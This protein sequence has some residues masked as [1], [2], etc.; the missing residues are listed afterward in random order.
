[1]RGVLDLVRSGLGPVVLP[2]SAVM[3]RHGVVAVPPAA[4]RLV[5]HRTGLLHHRGGPGETAGALTALL[6]AAA[7]PGR[8]A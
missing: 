3:G 2:R 4:P 5:V 8:A 7:P 6:T 1:M